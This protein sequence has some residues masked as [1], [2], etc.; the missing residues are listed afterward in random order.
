[1]IEID[2]IE[3]LEEQ[4]NISASLEVPENPPERYIVIEKTGNRMENFIE[5][6]TVAIKSHALT[7]VDAAKLN[8]EVKA[9][10]A[11]AIM[12]KRIH[13]A[14]LNADYNFTDTTKKGYRYQ[15]VYNF[16]YK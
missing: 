13:R 8:E 2:L 6:P 15:A 7:M 16:T 1:M 12:L 11:N 4:L 3:Y 10:M 5:F 9:V 14:E